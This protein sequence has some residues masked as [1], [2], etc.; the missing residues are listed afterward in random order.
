MLVV[1][2]CILSPISR[3]TLSSVRADRTPESSRVSDGPAVRRP[4]S[5]DVW[6]PLTLLP[7]ASIHEH[8]CY[9]L[10]LSVDESR[11]PDIEF[12]LSTLSVFPYFVLLAW[13]CYSRDFVV[14]ENKS[15]NAC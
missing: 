1:A 7:S 9:S 8:S 4:V 14:F 10:Q 12:C 15:I 2:S 11:Q 13:L 6:P 5:H 3:L